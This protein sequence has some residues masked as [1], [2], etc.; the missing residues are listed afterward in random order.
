[1]SKR[2]TSH[3]V[4]LKYGFRSGLEENLQS[5]LRSN[6]VPVVYEQLVVPW[7]LFRKCTYR[8]D[9]VLPNGIIIEGKGRFL[10]SDRQKHL[11]IKEQEP[12][13]E[14]R[15]VFSRSGERISK[16]SST[17]YAGWCQ[18]K[19]FQYADKQIDTRWLREP[20]NKKSLARIR[21]LMAANKKG[22]ACPF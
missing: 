2:L 3:E 19:G 10:T 21:E 11:Y 6:G 20:V 16:T 18:A 17:T 5:Q 7:T 14:I 13:L 12:D 4:G 1:L 9:F 22:P 15:F 8:P